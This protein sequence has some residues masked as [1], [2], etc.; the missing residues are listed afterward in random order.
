M[1]RPTPAG[2]L[3]GKDHRGNPVAVQTPRYIRLLTP[4]Q[5]VL[6]AVY[7]LAPA[8]QVGQEAVYRSASA[9]QVG[10]VQLERSTSRLTIGKR[11][12]HTWGKTRRYLL[13]Q[14]YS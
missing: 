7:R 8:V 13:S 6:G 1:T 2:P 14:F 4:R 9:V 11:K 10:P 3:T 12:H 5:V